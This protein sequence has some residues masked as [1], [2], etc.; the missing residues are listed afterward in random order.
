MRRGDRVLSFK[1][2]RDRAKKGGEVRS[3]Y[4]VSSHGAILFYVAAKPNCTTNEI[5]E[6]MALTHRTVWGL[7]G[8]LRRARMLDVRREGRRHRYT[9]NL[10]APFAHPCLNGYTLRAIL[11]HIS[12]PAT[13]SAAS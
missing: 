5:A 12:S 9:V 8:D 6:A 1:S 2:F 11:G 7:L 4:L 3:F 10:D 13:Q